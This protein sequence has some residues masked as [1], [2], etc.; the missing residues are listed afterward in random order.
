ML[1]EYH[2]KK[3]LHYF[4]RLD[5]D[6]SGFINKSDVEILAQRFANVRE[7][8]LG[9]EIHKDLLL[10]LLEILGNF[11]SKAD[12][13]GD[14][15]INPEEFCQTLEKRVLNL[16]YNDPSIETLFDIID[17]DGD[18]HIS[19]QEHRLF[20]S[21]FDLDAE[22]SALVFS[23]L[24]TDED[25]ILAKKEFIFAKKEYLNEREPGA[26]GNWFWGFMEA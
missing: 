24:D 1:S 11:E 17:L 16:D 7:A 19:Q 21:L 23:K 3:L 8:E 26:A 10:K 15:Q 22:Q 2:R 25:G 14:A 20:F 4:S 13:D 12:S 5:V 9:S 6:N 18:G